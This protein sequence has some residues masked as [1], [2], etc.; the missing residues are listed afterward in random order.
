MTKVTDISCRLNILT[1]ERTRCPQQV[2]G[3]Y[4]LKKTYRCGP[5]TK[6]NINKRSLKMDRNVK[7]VSDYDKT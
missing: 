4:C 7:V 2:K 6:G 5:L 3:M 1:I